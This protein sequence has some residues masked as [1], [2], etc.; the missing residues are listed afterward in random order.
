MPDAIPVRLTTDDR[1]PVMASVLG[2]AFVRDPMILWP[3]AEAPDMEA[4]VAR[5]FATIYRDFMERG[6]MWEAGDGAGFAHWVPPGGAGEALE[7]TDAIMATLRELTDD[8]G[9]RYEILWEWVETRIPSDVLYLDMLGVDP[10]QQG[11]GVG[12][13]LLRFG[14][15]RADALGVDAF[16]ETAVE[17]N[18]AYYERF[19][20]RVVEEG[21]V[22]EGPR[23][24]FMRAEG[25]RNG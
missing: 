6:T 24:W 22:D 2:R 17:A 3:M 9:T 16:L 19:G 8:E 11:R 7:T 13:A 15:E 21:E 25:G 14:L 18:V 10:P 20:F 1:L 23:I 4:R 12:S 5:H